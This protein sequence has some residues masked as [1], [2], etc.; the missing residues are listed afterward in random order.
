VHSFVLGNVF[1]CT[2]LSRR[3]IRVHSFVLKDVF[4]CAVLS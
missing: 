2:I 1:V 4:V 3:C